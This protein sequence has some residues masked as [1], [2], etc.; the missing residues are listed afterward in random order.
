MT[1]IFTHDDVVRYLYNEIPSDQKS[2][3]ENALICDNEL[4]DLF[5]ELRAVK[6]KLG[7]VV[8]NPSNQVIK[9]ILDYSKSFNLHTV[10]DKN[11]HAKKR[12]V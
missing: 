9:S 5:H 10:N 7:K 11:R 12:A 4:L 1:K 6:K 2:E 8:K 3:F